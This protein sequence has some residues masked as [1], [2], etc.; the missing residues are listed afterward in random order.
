MIKLFSCVIKLP[1]SPTVE[2]LVLT[3]PLP[4]S[5]MALGNMRVR[6]WDACG[7]KIGKNSLM[8]I[9]WL[10]V[11]Q[12][13][14]SQFCPRLLHFLFFVGVN[15]FRSLFFSAQRIAFAAALLSSLLSNTRQ[16]SY[17]GVDCP[18]PLI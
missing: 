7:P 16:N 18:A 14:L 3:S 5:F 15:A 17:R 1:K 8:T 13:V 11:L 12:S 4:P 2:P 9:L 6:Q 10:K